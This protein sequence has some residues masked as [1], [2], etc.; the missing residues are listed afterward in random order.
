MYSNVE[1]EHSRILPSEQLKSSDIDTFNI[2]DGFVSYFPFCIS[3][4]QNHPNNPV[5]IVL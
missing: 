1:L 3:P 2:W 4:M 5:F